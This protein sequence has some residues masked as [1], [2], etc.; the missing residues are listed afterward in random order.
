MPQTHSASLAFSLKNFLCGADPDTAHRDRMALTLLSI[1]F[2]VIE[3]SGA[4]RSKQ[5]GTPSYK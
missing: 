4:I 1:A 5:W 2:R 3:I